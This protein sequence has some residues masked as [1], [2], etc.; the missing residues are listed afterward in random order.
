[1]APRQARLPYGPRRDSVDAL[2][3]LFGPYTATAGPAETAVLT[4]AKLRE[5]KRKI[6]DIMNP[7]PEPV[8]VGDLVLGEDGVYAPKKP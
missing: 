6:D 3:Y 2:N 5:A 7:R 4:L 8:Q 1:M